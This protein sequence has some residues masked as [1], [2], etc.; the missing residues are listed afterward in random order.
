MIIAKPILYSEEDKN[1]DN[2]EEYLQYKYEAEFSGDIPKAI[3]GI[4]VKGK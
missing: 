1:C 4:K 3:V 2:L